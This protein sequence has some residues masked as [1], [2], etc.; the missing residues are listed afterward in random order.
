MKKDLRLLKMQITKLSIA[1][2]SNLRGGGPDGNER[3]SQQT[4]N[5]D[6]RD[7]CGTNDTRKSVVDNC[8][9]SE[10]AQPGGSCQSQGRC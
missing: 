6:E 3:G 8:R 4:R 1:Q 2:S 5:Q 9:E 10:N 7:T